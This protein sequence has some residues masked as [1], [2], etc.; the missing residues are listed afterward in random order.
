MAPDSVDAVGPGVTRLKVN[1]GVFGQFFHAPVGRGTYAEY[2]VAPESLGIAVSPRGMYNEPAAAIPT[3][4][5]TALHA[6]D[7]IGLKKRQS[8]LI[9]GASGGVGSFAVQLAANQGITTIAASRGANQD[10]LHKLGASRF[11]DASAMAFRDDVKRSYPD[12]VDAIL[13]LA[14]QGEEF[15]SYLGLVRAGGTVAST[16]GAATEAVAGP[17]GL[18]GLNIDLHPSTALLD[19][20]SAEFSKGMLRVPVEQKV[21]LDSAPD[22]LDASRE[23]KLRGKTVL[24]I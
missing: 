3:P 10:Y 23:G 21:P 17:R 14:H 16:I 22:V 7:E 20:L 6:L 24:T 12:G 4:G 13:D 9:L 18:R 5:M 11:F 8:L 2:V 1:D 19:R 15:E